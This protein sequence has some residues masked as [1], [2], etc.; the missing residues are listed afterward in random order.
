MRHSRQTKELLQL[1]NSNSL[2]IGNIIKYYP[3]IYCFDKYRGIIIDIQPVDKGCEL[4]KIYEINRKIIYFSH[5][6][7]NDSDGSWTFINNHIAAAEIL[8]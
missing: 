1:K 2:K 3:D 4:I 7:L 5:R 8:V 6:F